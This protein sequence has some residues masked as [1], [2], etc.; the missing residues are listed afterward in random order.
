MK[1]ILIEGHRGYRAKY[2]ENTLISFEAAMDYGVDAFEFDVWL[3]KDK[4]PVIMH[5]R[6]QNRFT[7]KRSSTP[8]T[9]PRTKTSKPGRPTTKPASKP[10]R[11]TRKR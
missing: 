4:I 2:T 3:T 9:T 1:S 7:R 8:A 5:G 10:A 11:A 6:S